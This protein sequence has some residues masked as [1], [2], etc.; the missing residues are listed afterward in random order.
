MHLDASALSLENKTQAAVP[1]Q[2]RSKFRLS[3]LHTEIVYDKKESF[4]AIV[5]IV[6]GLGVACAQP[7]GFLRANNKRIVDGQGQEVLLRGMGLG[8]WMLQEGYMLGIA[9]RALNIPSNRASPTWS[10]R[11]T[12]RNSTNSGCRIT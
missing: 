6:F 7:A 11:K 10:E 1:S 2:N 4:S 5:A 12:A 8:G 9:K 3:E